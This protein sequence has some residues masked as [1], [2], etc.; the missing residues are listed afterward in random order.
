LSRGLTLRITAQQVSA[1]PALTTPW[2][3]VAVGDN[4]RPDHAERMI[5]HNKASGVV[6]DIRL[7][8]T[9]V[10][11]PG[12][13]DF[14]CDWCQPSRP[15]TAAERALDLFVTRPQSRMWAMIGIEIQTAVHG[16]AIA[17][18]N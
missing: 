8:R 18:L 5:T 7:S 3:L 15:T 10:Q 9:A 6:V 12:R 16:N 4:A 17:W 14:R 1:Q 13:S 2:A 11:R